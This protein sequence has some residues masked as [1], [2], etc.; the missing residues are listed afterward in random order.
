MRFPVVLLLF[1]LTLAR[2]S[3]IPETSASANDK[4]SIPLVFVRQ[5]SSRQDLQREHPILNRSLDIIAGPKDTTQPSSSELQEPDAIT[6]DAGERVFVTD[7]QAKAV[8]VFDFPQSKYSRLRGGD[9]TL[10][11]G[12]A[13]DREGRIYVSDNGLRTVLVYDSRGKFLHPLKKLRGSESFFDSVA[14]VAIDSTTNRIY[15]C[16]RLRHMVIAFD[17]KGRVLAQFGE[18]TAG[19]GPGEFHSPAQV[20]ASSRQVIILDSY[21]CRLQFFDPRGRFINEF[22]VADCGNGSGLAMDKDGSIYVSDPQLNRL[23]VYSHAGQF[24]SVFGESGSAPGQFSG[25]SG[26]WVDRGRCLY[27]ADGKNKRV[28]SFRIASAGPGG[29]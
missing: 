15:V 21:N 3:T 17:P 14:G 24:L 28:Q 5:F 19:D 29:C 2:V 9:L 22:R 8:H 23:E 16:D 11:V 10:P 18:R 27:V 13:V 12:V 6:T 20:I 25:I 7:A 1:S 26:L 4:K